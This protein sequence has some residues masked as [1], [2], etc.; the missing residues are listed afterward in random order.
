[1]CYLMESSQQDVEPLCFP[2]RKGQFQHAIR[3]GRLLTLQSMFRP[4]H[5]STSKVHMNPLH[6]SL[7]QQEWLKNLAQST[8]QFL[9]LFL[10]I[11]ENF[12]KLNN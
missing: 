7:I 12:K 5:H 8:S 10:K 3:I 9:K 1:M 2:F 6:L 11:Q 4:L